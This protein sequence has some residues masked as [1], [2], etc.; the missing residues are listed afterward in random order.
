[1]SE[2]VIGSLRPHIWSSEES[3][4]YEAAIEAVNGVVGAYSHLIAD[5]EGRL[6]A[7]AEVAEYQRLRAAC[8]QERRALRPEDTEGVARVRAVYAARLR[9]LMGNDA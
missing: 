8:H 2:P 3:V 6:G 5:A 9:D 4:A 7:E 1:M